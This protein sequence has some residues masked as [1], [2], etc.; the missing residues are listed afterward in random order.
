M[1]VK[2]GKVYLVGIGPGGASD[3]TERARRAISECEVL[4][5]YTAY[6]DLLRSVIS[7]LEGK[8]ILTTS[9]RQEM[10]RCAAA[11]KEASQGK[12]VAMI[13]SGD[14]GIYGMAGPVLEMQEASPESRRRF[15]ARPSSARP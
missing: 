4:C 3:M 14:A 7:G 11:L 15:R 9:M 12:S 1:A 6:L 8:K 10:E 13:C 5:G 2:H